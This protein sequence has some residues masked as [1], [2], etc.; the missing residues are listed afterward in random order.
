MSIDL[1]ELDKLLLHTI[2]GTLQV[3]RKQTIQVKPSA[4]ELRSI[5]KVN[6]ACSL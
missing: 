2:L 5:T 3:Q 6:F 1:T 4:T